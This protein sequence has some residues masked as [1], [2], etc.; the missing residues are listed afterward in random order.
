M[1][2]TT[3]RDWQEATYYNRLDL[4]EVCCAQD[5]KLTEEIRSRGGTSER[6]AE[7]NGFNLSKKNDT[8]ELIEKLKDHHTR[9]ILVTHPVA[10]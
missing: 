4:A 3:P 2:A 9:H 10:P 8:Y 1:A 7:W 5:S 6:F